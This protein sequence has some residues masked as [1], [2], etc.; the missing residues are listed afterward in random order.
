MKKL[1]SV[2]L[3]LFALMP[4]V[5]ASDIDDDSIIEELNKSNTK[6]LDVDFKLKSFDSCQAFEDVM[7]D[8]LKT[9]WEN[10]YKNNRYR[11]FGE[12]MM[13]ESVDFAADAEQSAPSAESKSANAV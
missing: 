3:L 13:L 12:P 6:Q 7:E 1:S 5:F 4:V 2:L 11:T 10:S 9:Y 8:Y